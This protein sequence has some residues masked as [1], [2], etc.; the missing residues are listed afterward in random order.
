MTS[1]TSFI[2]GMMTQLDFALAKIGYGY[3]LA[4][5]QSCS[6]TIPH[7]LISYY[8]SFKNTSLIA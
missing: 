4:S 5:S 8:F 7:Y 6:N 2:A 1:L 3:K